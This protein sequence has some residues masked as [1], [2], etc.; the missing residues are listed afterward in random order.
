MK[1]YSRDMLRNITDKVFDFVYIDA[2]RHSRDVLEDAILSWYLIK[3]GG[4]LIFD[5]Y[6][7]SHENDNNCP[8]PAI[9]AFLNIYSNELD[10][11]HSKWQVVI[12]KKNPTNRQ[13]CYSEDYKK[14]KKTPKIF[15]DIN[16]YK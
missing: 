13:P 4:L 11:I 6:T 14:P 16:K 8:R 15:K 9:D 1:G 3:K 10:I 5:D 7:N 2:S 12:K